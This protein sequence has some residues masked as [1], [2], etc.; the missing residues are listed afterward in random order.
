MTTANAIEP[1]SFDTENKLLHSLIF[2]LLVVIHVLIV[3]GIS[4]FNAVVKRSDVYDQS[5]R[6]M[7]LI[8]FL[9][10]QPNKPKV[11]LLPDIGAASNPRPIDATAHRANVLVNTLPLLHQ[12]VEPV[13]ITI[14]TPSEASAVDPLTESTPKLI[15]RDVKQLSKD[16]KKEFRKEFPNRIAQEFVAAKG[17]FEVFKRNVAAAAKNQELTYQTYTTVDGTLVTKVTS[18]IGSYCVSSPNPAGG[19]TIIE[20]EGKGM[21]VVTCPGAMSF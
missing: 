19:A 3:I 18:G 20:R 11:E 14:L 2:I 5:D 21:R 8:W 17:S 16:L 6:A 1:F 13:P 12:S 4:K 10:I 9:P 15:N 7:Q